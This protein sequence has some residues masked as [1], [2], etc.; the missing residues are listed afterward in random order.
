MM[1]FIKLRE[2]KRSMIDIYTPK[3]PNKKEKKMWEE[4]RQT[5]IMY[6]QE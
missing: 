6:Y 1:L 4:T 2:R 3:I 5:V